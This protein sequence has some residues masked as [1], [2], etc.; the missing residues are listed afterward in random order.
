[1]DEISEDEKSSNQSGEKVA[2]SEQSKSN[3]SSS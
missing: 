2:A 1:M 3:Q